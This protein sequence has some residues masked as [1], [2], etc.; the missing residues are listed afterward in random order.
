MLLFIGYNSFASPGKK[1]A[2][3][4]QL[5]YVNCVI[6]FQAARSQSIACLE[7]I[8]TSSIVMQD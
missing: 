8:S 1:P 6:P 7:L 2:F 4:K 5:F 3:L